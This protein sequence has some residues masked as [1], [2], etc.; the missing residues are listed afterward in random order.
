[1]VQFD[2]QTGQVVSTSN[3]TETQKS[4]DYTPGMA[5]ILYLFGSI[6]LIGGVVLCIITWPDYGSS[7]VL[8][9]VS[10]SYLFAS[11]GI[12]FIFFGLAQCLTYLAKIDNRLKK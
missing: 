9:I 5:V 8:K 2:T 7:S 4:Y 11:I 6:F 1:M 10:L 12:S 3:S